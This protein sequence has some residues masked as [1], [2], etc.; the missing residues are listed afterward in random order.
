MDPND[1]EHVYVGLEEIYETSDGGKNWTTIGPYW[2][3]PFPCWSA[4]PTR[5]T[6][7]NT[8]HPDQ[9]AA[10][11]A[12]DG[13]AY[14]GNDGGMY[15]RPSGLRG[16][17]QWN[18]LNATLRTLQYYF[19]GI[20]ASP[21]GGDAIWGGMQDNGTSLLNPGAPQMVSPFG[22]DGG[23]VLVDPN[24][25]DRA[26][27]EYVFMTMART[28]NGGRSDGTTRS[29]TTITPTCASFIAIEFNPN[30]CDPNPRFI[31]PYLSD[32][33]N[34]DHWVAGGQM[35]W[36]NQG[37]GWDTVCNSTTCDWKIV[38]DLGPGSQT[39][40]L[41]VSGATIYAGWCGNGCNPGGAQPFKSGID[42]NFGGTWH[43]V[44]VPNL[45]NRIPTSFWVDPADDAHVVVTYGAFSRRWIPGGGVGH[46][47]ESH[48]GGATW[49]D[50]SGD[51]PD[52]PVNDV[53]V[54]AGQLYVG[55]DVGVFATSAANPGVWSRVGT[56]LP[57]RVDQRPRRRPRAGLHPRRHPRPRPLD[58]RNAGLTARRVQS[59]VLISRRL[60]PAADQREEPDLFAHLFVDRPPEPLIC[61]RS[62]SVSIS[63]ARYGGHSARRPTGGP[64]SRRRCRT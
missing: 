22:G 47:F 25:A 39:T 57:K 52:A 26:V 13:T 27:N 34:L 16:V 31:A 24:N 63:S 10:W 2:N 14:F 15:S 33:Q 12:A 60:P 46:V 18:D 19:A 42:T 56:N 50:R 49:A 64:R 6:C 59:T 37:K 35:V 62:S 38:R 36:D 41:G 58:V 30:P 55:T 61:P 4:D 9:H 8:T 20:G 44:D 54:N 5:N 7:P 1:A 40:S 17:V 45:P 3:F 21:A 32:P 43:R 23:A 29:Y 51:L 48:D 53:V 11:V 28:Q